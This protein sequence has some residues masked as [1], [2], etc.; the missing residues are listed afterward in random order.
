MKHPK[1]TN[2][3]RSPKL[4]RNQNLVKQDCKKTFDANAIGVELYASGLN[5]LFGQMIGDRLI[6]VLLLDLNFVD[7]VIFDLHHRDFSRNL[8]TSQDLDGFPLNEGLSTEMLEMSSI[9]YRRVSFAST[10]R[11][12]L[13]A[14]I[15][16]FWYDSHKIVESE[17]LGK[18]LPKD[19]D[20]NVGIPAIPVCNIRLDTI[21]VKALLLKVHTLTGQW[22]ESEQ[23]EEA[24]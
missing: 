8:E 21:L 13:C 18:P 2:K 19:K 16:W 11:T 9:E 1:S 10:S 20:G 3:P 15:D 12:N 14:Q 23:G 7:A 22:R 17:R 24:K 5:L 4:M 6:N